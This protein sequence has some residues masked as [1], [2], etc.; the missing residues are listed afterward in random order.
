[1]SA[2]VSLEFGARFPFDGTDNFWDG[3]IEVE[4]AMNW[5]HVAARG[6]LASICSSTII[7]AVFQRDNWPE[8]DRLQ[9]V[10]MISALIDENYRHPEQASSAAAAFDVI[11]YL[12]S[13]EVVDTAFSSIDDDT[14]SRV[15]NDVSETIHLCFG[16]LQDFVSEELGWDGF[17]GKPA[18]NETALAVTNFLLKC[19][20]LGFSK[21]SLTLS[22]SGAVS[23][24]WKRDFAYVTAN[25]KDSKK[26]SVII[27]DNGKSLLS[28]EF[29]VISFPKA[30]ND[31]L[32][33]HFN[34]T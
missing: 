29:D 22:N 11:N 33:E 27:L 25:F 16:R 24:I 5:Q 1:M 28:Q 3:Y 17:D 30:L 13:F 18:S 2:T 14:M 9:L 12:R 26:F 34:K 10:A 19:K 32:M 15:L 8:P 6:V 21:P 4:P 23:V 31:Y 20:T 7:K